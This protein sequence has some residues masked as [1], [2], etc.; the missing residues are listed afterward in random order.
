M[1]QAKLLLIFL[2]ISTT[3]WSQDFS[4]NLGP[5]YYGS[6]ILKNQQIVKGQLFISLEEDVVILKSSNETMKAFS[7]YQIDYFHFY[8]QVLRTERYYRSFN[9]PLK[10]R[11]KNHFFEVLAVGDMYYLRQ[12]VEMLI[13]SSDYRYFFGDNNETIGNKTCFVYYLYQNDEITK[14]K[15]FKR[16]FLNETEGYEDK[17]SSYALEENI[18]FVSIEDQI[19]IITYYNYL[20]DIE[21]AVSKN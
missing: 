16:Q 1:K 18:N 17:L 14:I 20:K 7:A 19:K 12:E 8:D 5:W 11:S 13:P 21:Q 15:N 4:E 3:S 10:K 2:L 9:T 6:I